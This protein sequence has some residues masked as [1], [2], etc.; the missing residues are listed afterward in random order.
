MKQRWVVVLAIVASLAAIVAITIGGIV[1]SG[2]PVATQ[3]EALAFE[4]AVCDYALNGGPSL[5]P[6]RVRSN[7]WEIADPGNDVPDSVPPGADTIFV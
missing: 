2:P 5:A 4:D 6:I 1:L 7:L 3:A